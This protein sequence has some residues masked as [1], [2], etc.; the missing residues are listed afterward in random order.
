[1]LTFPC[2]FVV[3]IQVSERITTHPTFTKVADGVKA[4]QAT[5]LDSV[6]HLKQYTADAAASIPSHPVV[7]QAMEALDRASAALAGLKQSVTEAGSKIT[8]SLLDSIAVARG[9]AVEAVAQAKSHLNVRCF[10][11][12]GVVAPAPCCSPSCVQT[13]MVEM[14]ARAH[15]RAV[16]VARK[17]GELESKYHIQDKATALVTK[18]NLQERYAAAECTRVCCLFS[19]ARLVALVCELY[20]VMNAAFVKAKNEEWQL[21]HRAKAAVEKAAALDDTWANGRGAALV[22]W[23]QGVAAKSFA[24]ASGL[25]TEFQSAAGTSTEIKAI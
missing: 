10:D 2:V 18:L 16:A 14:V 1:V 7:Q 24:Y 15:D 22:N 11:A 19:C 13:L 3:Y 17:A 12:A 4:H 8:D 25:Y 20:V 6:T 9:R 21:V 23:G 5:L